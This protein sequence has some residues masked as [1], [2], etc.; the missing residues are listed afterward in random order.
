MPMSYKSYLQFAEVLDDFERS[1]QTQKLSQ[2]LL[3]QGAFESLLDQNAYMR[4]A[5]QCI[6]SM[7]MAREMNF[8]F[9]SWENP[10]SA[11]P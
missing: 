5:L 10:S 8:S 7:S 11:F 6:K 1:V 9:P 2:F 4:N 3:D